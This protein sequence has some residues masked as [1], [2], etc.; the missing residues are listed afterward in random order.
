MPA[1]PLVVDESARLFEPGTLWLLELALHGYL[2]V[3]SLRS[4][5]DAICDW[6]RTCATNGWAWNSVHDGHLYAYRNNM[7]QEPSAVTEALLARSTINARVTRIY[8]FYTFA[9]RRG[10]L[11]AFPFSQR[12]RAFTNGERSMLSHLGPREIQTSVHRLK[13][14]SAPPRLVE[15]TLLNGLFQRLKPLDRLIVEWIAITG[16]RRF[17]ILALRTSQLPRIESITRP[18]YRVNI[19]VT[20][21]SRPRDLIVPG[22]LIARTWHYVLGAR[23]MAM[24]DARHAGRLLQHEDIIW[25]CS[26]G[27]PIAARTLSEHF[28]KAARDAGR[29]VRLH[30]LRHTFAASMLILLSSLNSG[31]HDRDVNAIQIVRLLLG[32]ISINTTLKYLDTMRLESPELSTALQAFSQLSNAT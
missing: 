16:A 5:A 32:H 21:G 7:L 8:L 26:T 28:L 13:D 1:V 18:L 4:Y 10:F 24:Q 15:P 25:Q 12:K 6:L 23:A 22:S 2:A 29:P 20:K 3:N 14:I 11:P 27:R 9:A 30:D 17:E 31:E 19:T